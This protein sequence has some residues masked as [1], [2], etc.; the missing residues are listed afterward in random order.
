M[1]LSSLRISLRRNLWLFMG[2]SVVGLLIWG[3]LR[4]QHNVPRTALAEPEQPPARALV[5]PPPPEAPLAR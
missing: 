4:Y 1:T 5:T 3:R 2:L